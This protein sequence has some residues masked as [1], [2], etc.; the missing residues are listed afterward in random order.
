VFQKNGILDKVTG[1]RYRRTVLEPGGTVD[2]FDMLRS[3]LGREP[4]Q[5]A[6]LAYLGIP[7]Q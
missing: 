1:A 7:P 3:F 4:N 2:G 5:D 6:Y